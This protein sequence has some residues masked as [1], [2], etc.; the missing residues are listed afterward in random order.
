MGVETD[1]ASLGTY[2]AI[3]LISRSWKVMASYKRA[4]LLPKESAV[5]V[6]CRPTLVGN[7]TLWQSAND[8]T[9]DLVRTISDMHL[10]HFL[11]PGLTRKCTSDLAIFFYCEKRARSTVLLMA[12][13]AFVS[14]SP[15]PGTSCPPSCTTTALE[16][17]VHNLLSS[18]LWPAQNVSF[19]PQILA[20]G[21]EMTTP[22]IWW[23]NCRVSSWTRAAGSH[24]VPADKN[25]AHLNEAQT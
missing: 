17:V 1:T 13:T 25:T 22:S 21:T 5:V 20:T 15:V 7:S 8:H 9:F 19:L 12:C 3:R 6:R 23:L 10:W 16:W 11:N 24:G 14:I 4:G 18:S 2:E